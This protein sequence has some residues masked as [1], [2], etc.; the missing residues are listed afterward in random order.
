M[1]EFFKKHNIYNMNYSKEIA[2]GEFKEWIQCPK[3]TNTNNNKI[4][5]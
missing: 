1:E 5:Y 3:T 4:N 2:E